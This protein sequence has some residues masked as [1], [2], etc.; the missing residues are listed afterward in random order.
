MDSVVNVKLPQ[1]SEALKSLCVGFQVGEGS[2]EVEDP[3]VLPLE[4][5]RQIALFL[6][7]FCR[8]LIL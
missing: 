1:V 7:Y 3:A 5:R 8:V 6:I 2:F 4:A